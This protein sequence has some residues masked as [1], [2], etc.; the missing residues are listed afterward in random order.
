MSEPPSAAGRREHLAH[1]LRLEHL[2]T[3]LSLGVMVWLARAKRRAGRGLS[4]PE[5][6]VAASPRLL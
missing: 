5:R 3:A 1:A 2:I 4:S 6:A